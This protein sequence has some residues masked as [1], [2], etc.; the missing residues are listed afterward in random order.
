RILIVDQVD[1]SC[2][3]NDLI[4]LANNSIAFAPESYTEVAY[5]FCYAVQC[6]LP[7]AHPA[8]GVC[9]CLNPQFSQAGDTIH[10]H[11]Q[12]VKTDAWAVEVVLQ[13]VDAQEAACVSRGRIVDHP[14]FSPITIRR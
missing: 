10:I 14:V 3:L 9:F 11:A 2:C 6:V 7:A 12:R 5:S 1:A 8:L 13:L 4:N